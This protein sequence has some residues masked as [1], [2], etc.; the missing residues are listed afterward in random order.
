VANARATAATNA[1]YAAV[2][3]TAE[4]A[5]RYPPVVLEEPLVD[6]NG[7]GDALA[8]GFLTSHVL[9]DRPLDQAVHRGQVAAR[10]VCARRSSA[11]SLTTAQLDQ[12]D[13]KQQ[14]HRQRPRP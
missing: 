10:W 3:G 4:G 1:A 2:I 7:A 8:V 13:A 11:L 12:L 6:T 14:R 9:Q 5:R